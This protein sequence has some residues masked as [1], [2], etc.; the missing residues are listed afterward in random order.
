M[1][2]LVGV[3]GVIGYHGV[4]T[5]DEEAHRIAEDGL[6]MDH[7]SEMVVAIEQQQAA[8]QAAR[9]GEPDARERFQEGATHFSE[10]AQGLEATSLSAEQQERLSSIRSMHAEYETLATEF[11]RA[12]EAGNEELA[13]QKAAEMDTLRTEM[14]SSAHA[15]EESAQADLETQ[16]AA[17]D[18]TTQ[19][20]QYEMIGATVLAFVVALGV[21]LFVARRIS[22]PIGQLSEGAV[23][24]GRGE[25]DV[26][27]DDH[28]EDDEIGR[29]VTA[30][31]EM[32]GTLRAVFAD[33]DD[34]RRARQP[35]PRPRRGGDR[36]DR[37]HR[38]PGRG[39]G[40]PDRG[41]AR[42]GR[43]DD[44]TRRTRLRNN[45][46]SSRDVRRDRR[47]GRRSRGRNPGDQ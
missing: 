1:A 41:A 36:G 28:V 34:G 13:A 46:G 26:E 37:V 40:S 23:A 32:Q 29:M 16:V 33:L 47:R 3:T 2:L 43:G 5:V 10:E 20:T 7:A 14:E 30:F 12:T 9:L 24:I 11:F 35:G 22:T 15:I 17:A 44:D 8:V 31:K 4:G 39:G 18:A 21:G 25:F 42:R 19:R 38:G 6:K 45:R 27:V